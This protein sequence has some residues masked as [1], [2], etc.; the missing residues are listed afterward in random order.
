M[1]LK[2]F[3]RLVGAIMILWP[4]LS[5]D[6]D[7]ASTTLIIPT[8]LSGGVRS[9]SGPGWYIYWPSSDNPINGQLHR[10]PYS[11]EDQCQ[12]DLKELADREDAED[13]A[14]G[15]SPPPDADQCAYFGVR[16]KFDQPTK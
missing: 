12:A 6:A 14:I 10:G 15:I 8:G 3:V 11:T 1:R 9:W 4:F 13:R 5:A 7:V 2:D 16:P